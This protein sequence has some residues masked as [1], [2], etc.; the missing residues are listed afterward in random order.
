MSQQSFTFPS[1]TIID[2]NFLNMVFPGRDLEKLVAWAKVLDKDEILTLNDAAHL[3]EKDWESLDLPLAV[4]RVLAATA[5]SASS[6]NNNEI[7]TISI[8]QEPSNDGGSR[9]S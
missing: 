3:S 6:V 9:G 5:A 2:L 7:L 8:K 1:A 4:G